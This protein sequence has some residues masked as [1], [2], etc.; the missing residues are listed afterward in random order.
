M[1]TDWLEAVRRRPGMFVGDP[2]DGT[3]IEE[4]LFELVANSLDA[5]LVGTLRGIEITLRPGGFEVVDDGPGIAVER[6]GDSG[7][8][9][10]E[11]VLTNFHDAP[12]A[13]GHAPH[14]HLAGG[15]GLA[16]VSAL[17]SELVVQTRGVEQ[18][19]GRGR[20]LGAAVPAGATGT[21]FVGTLDPE[22]FPPQGWRTE[23]TKARLRIVAAHVPGLS[24]TLRHEGRFGEE[25]ASFGPYVGPEALLDTG[26]ASL[27]DRVFVLRAQEGTTYGD[28]ALRFR[29]RSFG[30]SFG[31]GGRLDRI[32]AFCNFAR[33]AKGGAHVEGFRRGLLRALGVESF[34][35]KTWRAIST[36][37]AVVSVRCVDPTYFGPTR[38]TLASKELG[39]FF[40]G[41]V[42]ARLREQLAKMPEVVEVLRGRLEE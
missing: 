9:F 39:P 27:G 2:S 25:R 7:R 23:A 40:E 28:V 24:I 29:A 5:A 42:E 20:A 32:D 37:D 3:G 12:T 34:S 18:R 41:F 13:D 35:E 8:T 33:V 4:L 10:L 14:V 38:D 30:R 31:E 17:C 1:S 22:I 15:F 19:F 6:S 36:L 26:G 16:L 21:R 11:E